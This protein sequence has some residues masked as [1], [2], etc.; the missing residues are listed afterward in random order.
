M[1]FKNKL[2]LRLKMIL[3]S[4]VYTLPIL[5][6]VNFMVSEQNKA[7]DFN[8]L[9]LI[10]DAYLRPLSSLLQDVG[11]HYFLLK[12]IKKGATDNDIEE[13]SK[14]ET[15]IEKDIADLT[16][17]QELYGEALQFTE[18]GLGKR[19]RSQFT[20]AQFAKDWANFVKTWRNV[21]SI[22]EQYFKFYSHLKVMIT[23]VGDT[24]N[25]I[26]D[27]ELD[28]FYLMDAT[29]VALPSLQERIMNMA[30]FIH[31]NEKIDVIRQ[32][33]MLS[34]F[35]ADLDR[36][37]ASTQTAISEDANFNGINVDLTNLMPEALK[38]FNARALDFSKAFLENKNKDEIFKAGVLLFAKSFEFW[39]F[40]TKTLDQLLTVRNLIAK[41]EQKT[42][43][44]VVIGFWL[45]A[46][47]L[48]FFLQRSVTQPIQSV[49][50]QLSRTSMDNREVSRK[51]V[52]TSVASAEA[53]MQETKAIQEA[54]AAMSQMSSMITLTHQHVKNANNRTEDV[55]AETSEGMQTMEDMALAM[56]TISE[57]NGRLNEITKII[58]AI[59]DKTNV[60]NE[61]V[62]KTQLLS[63]NASIE[64]ARAGQHGRGFA[65]VAEEVRNLSNISGKAADEIR[66]L[67]IDSRIQVSD[68]VVK[69]SSSINSGQKVS[70]K[71]YD[72]FKKI[73]NSVSDVAAKVEMIGK[74]TNE[75][76]I[77][78]RQTSESMSHLN[79]STNVN[80]NL[81]QENAGLGSRVLAISGELE[82]IHQ[83]MKLAVLGSAYSSSVKN[84]INDDDFDKLESNN[85]ANSNLININR[86]NNAD[87]FSKKINK[88]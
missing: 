62:F 10:G 57:T 66:Q 19:N 6:L 20:V 80:A 67:L 63:V 24:S 35:A 68:T 56:K 73:A 45:F 52:R 65:V 8:S 61:I 78:V 70:Q 84:K 87:N 42:T 7:I 40:E 22:D 39:K 15:F 60:I 27:P 18:A 50:Q 48:V 75:Q 28:S 25:L 30:I 69:T 82:K 72:T 38:D 2:S 53:S 16:Q 74:A 54:V 64:A 88:I 11:R 23:H 49:L 32:N 51:L 79:R 1:K 3:L 43:L 34:Q 36:T 33:V 86:Q 5:V 81:A 37:V 29:L 4:A 9:E 17:V 12:N 44:A 46:T 59:S 85:Q 58:E 47:F 31:S 83:S 71:A 41:N 77:G 76:E 55:L 21:N 13:L 14:V 26:L